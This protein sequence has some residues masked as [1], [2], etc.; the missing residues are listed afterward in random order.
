MEMHYE[1]IKLESGILPQ[2]VAGE[3][4]AAYLAGLRRNFEEIQAGMY[5]SDWMQ[6]YQRGKI[7]EEDLVQIFLIL[8]NYGMQANQEQAEKEVQGNRCINEGRAGG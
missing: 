2:A 4:I 5:C 3:K 6:D 8:L 7:E 1:I